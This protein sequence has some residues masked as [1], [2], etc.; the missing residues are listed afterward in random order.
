MTEPDVSVIHERLV[1]LCLAMPTVTT[2]QAWWP[3]NE[4]PFTD[5]QL[6][7]AIVMPAP[8]VNNQIL[9]GSE[10]Q[11]NEDWVLGFLVKRFPGD[12][13]LR[14]RTTWGLVRPFIRSVPSYFNARRSLELTPATPGLVRGITLPSVFS[15]APA[16]FDQALY[17]AVGFRMTTY[18]IHSS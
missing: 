6:P 4:E 17:A 8:N 16:S 11:T 7:A 15:L 3:D 14:D 13:D 9:S 2:A 10:Y 18:T 5:A 12:Y 1:A